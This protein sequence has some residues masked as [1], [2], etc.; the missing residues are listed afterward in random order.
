MV[1]SLMLLQWFAALNLRGFVLDPQTALDDLS[2]LH[3]D[4]FF[5]IT[6]GW[7]P[8]LEIIHVKGTEKAMASVSSHWVGFCGR[9]GGLLVLGG[10]RG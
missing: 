2:D 8:Y 3:L 7:T 9:V 1:Q 10:T 5:F 4:L 6:N